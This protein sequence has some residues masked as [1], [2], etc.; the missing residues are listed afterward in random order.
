MEIPA[1]PVKLDPGPGWTIPA[2]AP[3]RLPCQHPVPA[4]DDR[5]R[6]KGAGESGEAEEWRSM[7]WDA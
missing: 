5:A 7:K 6:T 2:L 1:P 3:R 4:K